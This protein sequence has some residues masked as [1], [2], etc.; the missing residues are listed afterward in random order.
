M[1]DRFIVLATENHGKLLEFRA[2]MGSPW[3]LKF[4]KDFPDLPPLP[5][6]TGKTYHEN[7]F[8][9]AHFVHEHLGF[10]VLADDSGFEIAALGN[11]P[12]LF[13]ARFGGE[14]SDAERCQLILKEMAGSE[15]RSARF[16]CVLCYQPPGE[17]PRYYEGEIK[18]E[19]GLSA[20]GGQGFGYD[21][22][23]IPEGYSQSFAELD[24]STK[25]RISHRAKAIAKVI[26]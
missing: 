17:T 15:D 12:G 25:N 1:A 13:S 11:R 2:L 24:V 23:F 19:V 14:I 20:R 9:K 3:N 16:V 26:G 8:I 10:A 21:P 18:G 22:I 5:P 4:L 7:A 6:E